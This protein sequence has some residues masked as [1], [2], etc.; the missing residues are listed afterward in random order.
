MKIISVFNNKGGV[1][2]TTLS[3]HMAYALTEMG[4]RVLMID[5]DPQCNLTIHSLDIKRLQSIWER[6]DDFIELGFDNTKKEYSEDEFNRINK[7]TRTIHY[8][9]KPIEEGTGDLLVLPPPYEITKNLSLIPGRLTLYMYENEI[10]SRWASAYIG[11]PLSIRTITKIRSLACEY[12]KVYGFDFVVIDTSPSLGALNKVI[13]STVDG[14][15]IPALP[16]MFSMY[17]IRNI[18]KSLSAWKRD[19]DA[20]YNLLPVVKRKQFPPEFVKFLGFT[21]YNAKKYKGNNNK[22]ELAQSDYNYAQKIP[23]TIRSYIREDVRAHLTDDMI[24]T[25][26]GGVNVMY[27]HNTLPRMAQKY[28]N[29]I[30]KIPELDYLD[31]E[32]LSTI[33]GNRKVYENTKQAYINFAKDL[34]VRINTLD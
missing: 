18:G 13:I 3:Y 4:Y 26:I 2:K 10:S 21:I 32:D 34:L 31:K 9:L 22:W 20:I 33:K 25:P 14:F 19:F 11:A 27:S 30:W 24:N 8:L 29:P 5:L 15:L 28:K 16:D 6:E 12:A 23:D 17:G 1:G 7:E